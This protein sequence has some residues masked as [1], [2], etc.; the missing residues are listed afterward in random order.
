MPKYQRN[1]TGIEDKIMP[2]YAAGMT[3]RD[4]SEQIKNLYEVEISAEMVSNI[5]NI[6]MPVVTELQNRPL[7]KTYSFVF[8]DAIHYKVHEDNHIIIK[9]AYVVL[10]VN[11]DSEKEVP[12]I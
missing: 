1:I 4:I 10:G 5:T 3:T 12:G 8:M 2:L 9:A 6:I 11:M 7:E